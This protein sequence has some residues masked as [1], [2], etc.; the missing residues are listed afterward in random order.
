MSDLP[1][2]LPNLEALLRNDHAAWNQCFNWLSPIARKVARLRLYGYPEEDVDDVASEVMKQLAHQIR[3]I[4]K[5]EALPGWIQM[6]AKRLAIDHHRKAS[7]QKRGK[8]VETS[9][10]ELTEEGGDSQLPVSG[11]RPDLDIERRERNSVVAKAL[12]RLKPPLMELLLG[13]YVIGLSYEELA[14]N[15]RMALGSVGP[16]LN[17]GI[18]Q[19]RSEMKR[20]PGVAGLNFLLALPAQLLPFLLARL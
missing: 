17:R 13:F 8:A 9:L 19:L 14:K 5:V 10:E 11:D 15:H 1:E 12:K 2:V 18:T 6:V 7:A 4:D 16:T 3:E 20:E